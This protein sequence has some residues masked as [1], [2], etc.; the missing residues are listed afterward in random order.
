M[1]HLGTPASSRPMPSQVAVLLAVLLG[2]AIALVPRLT[3]D[4]WPAGGGAAVSP[5]HIETSV[6]QYLGEWQPLADP[7]VTLENGIQ[8][9]SSNVNGIEIEGVR[10]YYRPVRGFS[11]DPVTRGQVKDYQVVL[12]LDAGTQWETEVYRV[13]G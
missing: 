2:A 5:Q 4:F 1:I 13:P 3:L 11:A 9:K 12:V 10:Y 7:L 8:V 6:R